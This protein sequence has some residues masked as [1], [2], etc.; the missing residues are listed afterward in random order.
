MQHNL[1]PFHPDKLITIVEIV[2]ILNATE[3]A[4][5]IIIQYR[6]YFCGPGIRIVEV[7]VLF[8]TLC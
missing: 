4:V 7:P 5:V 1:Q 8:V 2:P 3:V 6:G